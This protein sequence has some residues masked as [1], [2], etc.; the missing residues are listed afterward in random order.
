MS[1]D[2][3]TPG[4]WCIKDRRNAGE[5]F[6]I[7]TGA[8]C[9]PSYGGIAC[10]VD[11]EA[12]ARLIVEAPELADS[13]RGLIREYESYF[14]GAPEPASLIRARAVLARVDGEVPK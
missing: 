1:N 13:L 10:L 12:D 14:E 7:T 4:P 2:K 11:V 5:G 3:H 9:L 8:A 6:T